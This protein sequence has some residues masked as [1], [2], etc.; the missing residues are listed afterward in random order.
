[1]PDFN[2]ITKVSIEG[3]NFLI[4]G[5]PTLEGRSFHDVSIQGLLLNSRMANAVF[6]DGNRFTRHLW[7]YPDKGRWN[8]DRNTNELI[9]M[10]P[11]YA[12]R[13]LHCIDIN[14]QGC[15]STRLLQVG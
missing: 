2:P 15:V 1:M 6:D 11:T 13:G 14:L 5:V 9:E 12:E 7:E 3:D 8:A 4:N 10:L